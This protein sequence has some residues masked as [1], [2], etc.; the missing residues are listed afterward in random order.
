MIR[1]SAGKQ[2]GKHWLRTIG[3]DA[4]G[5]LDPLEDRTRVWSH[6]TQPKAFKVKSKASGTNKRL[7]QTGCHEASI[8]NKPQA[9]CTGSIQ[10]AVGTKSPCVIRL[11]IQPSDWAKNTERPGS[12]E[13]LART[14]RL[15][16]PLFLLPSNTGSGEELDA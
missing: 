8:V 12:D 3:I 15:R 16:K 10:R 4:S 14:P 7:Y 9:C 6:S 2:A 5:G 13:P 1:R 11:P